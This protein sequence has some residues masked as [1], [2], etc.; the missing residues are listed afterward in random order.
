M[1]MIFVLFLFFIVPSVMA[2]DAYEM[3]GTLIDNSDGT[4][5]VNLSDQTGEKHYYGNAYKQ[6]DGSLTMTVNGQKNETYIGTAV[7]SHEGFFNI[8]LF[9]NATGKPV[10]GTL[11]LQE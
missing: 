10:T 7:L 9:N 8:Q 6:A 11:E 1:K 5:S 3:H 2:F 4:Y